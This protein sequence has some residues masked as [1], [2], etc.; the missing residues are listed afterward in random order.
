MHSVTTEDGFLLTLLR[1]PHGLAT[2]SDATA[3]DPFQQTTDRSTLSSTQPRDRTHAA[4]TAADSRTA[5]GTGRAAAGSGTLDGGGKKTS[6]G[7]GLGLRRPVVFLQHGLLDSAA[8]YL[9]NGPGKSLGFILADLGE[10]GM[11]WGH[12]GMRG[13]RGALAERGPT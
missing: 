10:G 1:I 7:H 2:K 8:G 4:H 5:R 13:T 9:V 6:P 12:G 11:A 3:T